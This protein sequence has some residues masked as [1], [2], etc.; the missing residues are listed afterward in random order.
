MADD[1]LDNLSQDDNTESLLDLLN[2]KV[3][4][5]QQQDLI[6]SLSNKHADNTERLLDLMHKNADV[7]KNL[8]KGQSSEQDNKDMAYERAMS[9]SSPDS[10]LAGLSNQGPS[11]PVDLSPPQSNQLVPDSSSMFPG[12]Q[13]LPPSVPTTAPQPVTPAPVVPAAGPTSNTPVLPSVPK[14]TMTSPGAKGISPVPQLKSL[15]FGQQ[16]GL[17]TD[18][19]LQK[20]Q[21]SSALARLTN[22]LGAAGELIGSGISHTQPVAQKLFAD[23]AKESDQIT[24]DWE[25]RVANEKNDPNSPLS[26]GMK[27]YMKNLG[28]DIKGNPSA[29]D[30]AAVSPMVF[31]DFEAREKAKEMQLRT[32]ELGEQKKQT[33]ALQGALKAQALATT[34]AG[35]NSRQQESLASK[36]GLAEGSK[37][38]KATKDQN[39]AMQQTLTLL[40]SNRSSNPEV[41]QAYRDRYAASKA[42]TL[43]SKY[44]PDKLSPQQ[45]KLLTSELTKIATGGVPTSTEMAALTPSS[46]ESKFKELVSRVLNKPTE[47][48]LGA[49]VKQYQDYLKDLN[50]NAQKVIKDKMGRVIELKRGSVGEDNYNLLQKQYMSGSEEKSSDNLSG[51]DKK[52]VDWAKKN[53]NDP[54]AQTIL[55]MH[56]M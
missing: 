53:P 56:G 8:H 41:Q 25:Q 49:F 11:I 2:N 34:E 33:A 9:L 13:N 32:Q 38:G 30:L 29:S 26:Q 6:N 17:G 15:D 46:Y 35:K 10:Y 21:D 23:Q 1:Q 5:D 22:Q 42:L 52:A 18:E 51:D 28:F 44:D 4:K 36:E 14:Q 48:N 7:L 45:V 16:G 27:D 31:K 54:R 24:K 39:N 3:P 50:D 47:A 40:E 55:T 43:V 12:I 37:E 20:A 19:N